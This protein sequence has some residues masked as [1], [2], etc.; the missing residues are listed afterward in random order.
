MERTAQCHCGPPM[1]FLSGVDSAAPEPS[2]IP[3]ALIR[4]AKFGSRATTRFMSVTRTASRSAFVS[5][6]TAAAPL[7]G[8]GCPKGQAA[9]SFGRAT[10]IPTSTGSRWAAS[11]IR[12]SRRQPT[13][14]G[15]PWLGVTTET[16]HFPQGRPLDPL[17]RLSTIS[18]PTAYL[19]RDRPPVGLRR[20]SSRTEP[21]FSRS[22]RNSDASLMPVTNRSFAVVASATPGRMLLFTR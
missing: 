22:S 13:R 3:A 9:T 18:S 17:T 15:H 4:K 21:Q 1:H 12:T 19:P 10:G 16:E 5:A 2:F 20:L 8:T 11:S 14:R 6:R 7:R